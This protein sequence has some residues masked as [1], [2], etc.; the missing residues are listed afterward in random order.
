[1]LQRPSSTRMLVRAYS[2]W[3]RNQLILHSDPHI[4]HLYSTV[5]ADILVRYHRLKEPEQTALFVT[6]TDEHG[7]KIQRAAA[8]KGLEGRELE[9]CDT[10][11]QR[12]KVCSI[13]PLLLCD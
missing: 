9:F 7:S 13:N 10:I 5:L 4:G 2:L 6:G 12:F 1:M 11:S 3:L 8:S